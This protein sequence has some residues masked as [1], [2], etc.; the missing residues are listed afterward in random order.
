MWTGVLLETTELCL[1][2]REQSGKGCGRS[3]RCF[4]LWRC[5]IVL[6]L[7][8]GPLRS[9][10]LREARADRRGGPC[11]NATNLGL[12]ERQ[13]CRVWQFL[14]RPATLNSIAPACTETFFPPSQPLPRE[15][16]ID[17]PIRDPYCPSSI[18]HPHFPISPSSPHL[19]S[20]PVELHRMTAWHPHPDQVFASSQYMAPSV[21]VSPDVDDKSPGKAKP[22]IKEGPV[23][24]AC[25]NCRNKKAKCDGEQPVC[26]QVELA[27]SVTS[28]S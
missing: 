27:P 1:T 14:P 22:W 11:D 16:E 7:D 10:R 13:N 26:S 18:L 19:C 12:F 6:S 15:K 24:N 5:F 23:K 17:L 25:L 4:A 9:N 8:P 21:S 3:G 28:R 20:D 2:R